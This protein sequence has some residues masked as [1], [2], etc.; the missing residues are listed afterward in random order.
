MRLLAHL[1]RSICLLSALALLL[2]A[3]S[4]PTPS[5][6]PPTAVPA[7]MSTVRP[8]AP[9]ASPALGTLRVSTPAPP[10]SLRRAFDEPAGEVG[11]GWT[12]RADS[13]APSQP[14]ALCQN[15]GQPS[16]LLLGDTGATSA[17]RFADGKV[18]AALKLGSGGPAGLILRAQDERTYYLVRADATAG[19][20][21]AYLIQHGT[22]TPVVEAKAPVT[23]DRWQEL[24]ATISD[25]TLFVWLNNQQVLS[26]ADNTLTRPGL[27]G[28]WAAANSGACFDDAAA[29][30][31]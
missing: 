28:L 7:V 27:S 25:N 21:G 17:D 24:R 18:S 1:P 4:T 13:G 5:A 6:R 29:E 15:G 14:N 20:V 8:P 19:L 3:C 26:G 2:A 22:E 10:K 31:R 11:G 16:L 30:W 9:A 12:R 23:A